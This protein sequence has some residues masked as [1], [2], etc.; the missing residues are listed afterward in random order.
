[1]GTFAEKAFKDADNA[2]NETEFRAWQ[3]FAEKTFNSF[4]T[5]VAIKIGL[6]KMNDMCGAV[7][8]K[9]LEDV[10][11]DYA[12]HLTMAAFHMGYNARREDECQ[13]L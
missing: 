1:M 10:L 9:G 12:Y 2:A 11:A 3:R 5:A 13:S 8:E 6:S 7:V 4:Q